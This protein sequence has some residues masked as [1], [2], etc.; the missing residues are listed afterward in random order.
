MSKI[1]ELLSEVSKYVFATFP[2]GAIGT[3]PVGYPYWG[4]N[5]ERQ[6]NNNSHFPTSLAQ[7]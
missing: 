6:R 2:K 3:A 4:E 7:F 5:K 1:I